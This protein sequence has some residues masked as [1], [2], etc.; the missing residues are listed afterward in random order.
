MQPW[1]RDVEIA[2]DTTILSKTVFG[3]QAA[4]DHVQRAGEQIVDPDMT[5]TIIFGMGEA[6]DDSQMV[7]DGLRRDLLEAMART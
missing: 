1:S 3:S 5:H 2:G 4:L 7:A 6:I